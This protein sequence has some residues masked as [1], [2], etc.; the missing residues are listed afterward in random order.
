MSDEEVFRVYRGFASSDFLPACCAP[1]G[2][3]PVA[4][5]GL[6]ELERFANREFSSGK[7]DLLYIR[8]AESSADSAPDERFGMLGYDVGYYGS[9]TNRY[10]VILFEVVYGAIKQMRNTAAILNEHLLFPDLPSA[11]TLR[12]IREG[13]VR[14]GGEEQRALETFA[15]GEECTAYA[16]WACR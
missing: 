12:R 16:V 14:A 2:G 9:E 6:P 11:E 7:C 1:F 4:E 13:I 8:P 3:Q 5:E 10:S 15:D